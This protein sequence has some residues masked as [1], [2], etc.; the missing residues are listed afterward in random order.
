[1]TITKEKKI[2]LELAALVAL[3]VPLLTLFK[4]G[5]PLYYAVRYNRIYS[6]WIE[7]LIIAILS[8]AINFGIK[9]MHKRIVAIA[10]MI[11][12]FAYLH[13]TLIPVVASGLYLMALSLTGNL[14]SGVSVVIIAEAVLS[15]FGAGTATGIR[16]FVLIA[17]VIT[18][19][20]VLRKYS[21]KHKFKI[22]LYDPMFRLTVAVVLIVF[23]LN[24]CRLNITLDYDSLWYG[25]RSDHVLAP[26]GSIFEDLGLVGMVYTYSKGFE[27]L[28][29]PLSGLRSHAYILCFNLWIYLVGLKYTYKLAQRLSGKWLAYAA[30]IITALI[31]GI[32]NMAVSAKSDMFTWVLQI[33]M[34]EKYFEYVDREGGFS[35]IIPFY[36]LSLTMKPTAV[37]FSTALFGMMIVY[38]VYRIIRDKETVQKP[39]IDAAIILSAI[40]LI[41][42]W[43]RTF[44]LTGVPFTSVFSGVLEALGF[45]M[46]YPFTAKSLPQNYQERSAVLVLADRVC[47]MLLS[48][49]GKDMSHVIIAWG[50]SILFVLIVVIAI[51]RIKKC[52]RRT[53][54]RFVAIPFVIVNLISLAMLYQVDGN[55]YMMLYSLIIILAVYAAHDNLGIGNIIKLGF[56]KIVGKEKYFTGV[57]MVLLL[58][59]QLFIITVTNWSSVLGFTPIKLNKGLYNHKNEERIELMQDGPEIYTLLNADGGSTKVVAFAE[60]PTCLKLPCIV[61]S[62]SDIRAPWGNAELVETTDAFIEYLKFYEAEYLYCDDDFLNQEDWYWAKGLVEDM[63][64]RGIVT[65]VVREGSCYLLKVDL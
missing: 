38:A 7:L 3:L 1:M 16:I 55:Y 10:I 42:T 40:A 26:N 56:D 12:A 28:T 33:M 9:K 35:S 62:Y 51:F 34:L 32:T 41:I 59:F 54:M 14:I 57:L 21:F 58:V 8:F 65:E 13:S 50:G 29:L 44:I 48:P 61:E 31:P 4:E 30:V 46:K 64:S 11:L 47:K 2:I 15:L 36:L 53:A 20:I 25:F 6:E 24:L 22:N 19:V 18:A 60:H 63:Q 52:E 27:I 49:V 39:R 5:Y 45:S 23:L 37:I 17:T 43:T